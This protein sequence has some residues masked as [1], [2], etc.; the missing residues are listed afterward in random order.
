MAAERI[1]YSGGAPGADRLFGTLAE[2]CGF[3]ERNYSF[4]G[5]IECRQRGRVILTP[6]ELAE[7]DVDLQEVLGDAFTRAAQASD[8]SLR[9]WRRNWYQV[10]MTRQIFAVL[11]DR[12]FLDFTKQP[13]DSAGTAIALALKM[14]TCEKVCVYL[15]ADF[16]SGWLE[17]QRGRAQSRE[18]V[19]IAYSKE[20][21]GQRQECLVP[22]R[23]MEA[24]DVKIDPGDFTGIGTRRI[25][26]AGEKAIK[27]LYARSFPESW[28]A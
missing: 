7:A 18:T 11:D 5:H 17:W 23:T 8:K 1:L 25:N 2:L 3:S 6:E 10:R 20:A 4:E 19:S 16:Q 15:Q 9:Y 21:L 27:S 22:F 13:P 12:T 14:N 26:E 28:R 24:G